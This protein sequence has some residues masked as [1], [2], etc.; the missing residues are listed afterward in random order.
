MKRSLSVILL[1]ITSLS[2]STAQPRTGWRSSAGRAAARKVQKELLALEE[3]RRQAIKDGDA[4]TIDQI[5]ADDFIGIAG[6]GQLVTK[7]QLMAVLKRNDPRIG[8]TTDE[9]KVRVF[10]NSAVFT[11][12]LIGRTSD[13]AVVSS[14]RFTHVF[15]KRRGH[16]QCVA[17]QSTPLPVAA[18]SRG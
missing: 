5:Y 18:V 1:I 4:K 16:W 15:V 14:S 13:G 9:I 11:A 10:R 12:R 6:N 3:T 17:G 2:L 8:F 7:E